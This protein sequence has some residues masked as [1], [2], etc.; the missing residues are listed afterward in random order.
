[1]EKDDPT[2]RALFP[3]LNADIRSA[4]KYQ[5]DAN[6]RRSLTLNVFPDE[7]DLRDRTY[8]PGLIQVKPTVPLPDYLLPIG[9]L[10]ADCEKQGVCRYQKSANS[11]LKHIEW[12]LERRSFI[13]RQGTE[14]SCT[15]QALAAVI[16][17]LKLRRQFGRPTGCF[18]SLKE[19]AEFDKWAKNRTSARMLYEMARNYEFAPE[20]QLS[21][22]TIRNALKAFYHNGVCS[23]AHAPYSAGDLSWV[24]SVERAKD[25][26]GTMLGSYFRVD[27]DIHE[28]QAALN[29]VGAI[30]ASGMVH[31]GWQNLELINDQATHS[32][33]NKIPERT[34][35]HRILGGHAFAVVGYNADGFY[36]LNSWGDS[37]GR[38]YDPRT[39]TVNE[40][41]PGVALWTYADWHRHALDAWVFRLTHPAAKTV[42]KK[43]GWR[44]N[45]H[46]LS[47]ERSSSEPRLIINGH[48]LHLGR[49]GLVR[50]GKYPSELD[51]FEQTK[52]YLEE[53]GHVEVPGVEKVKEIPGEKYQSLILCFMS[54]TANLESDANMIEAL[55]RLFKSERHYPVFVFWTYAQVA[56]IINIVNANR[57]TL[58]ERYGGSD[59]SL[60]FRVD[61]ELSEFGW[62]FR[63]RME[64]QIFDLV[65]LKYKDPS[66]LQAATM[67]LIEWATRNNKKIH[68]MA[69]SDGSLLLNNY[70]RGLKKKSE[71]IYDRLQQHVASCQLVAPIAIEAGLAQIADCVTPQCDIDLI[72]L[73]VEEELIDTVGNYTSTYP[74]MLQNVFYPNTSKH[75][76]LILGLYAHAGSAITRKMNELNIVSRKN[77]KSIA[78]YTHTVAP[79]DTRQKQPLHFNMMSNRAL[80]N[81]MLKKIGE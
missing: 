21:G 44:R 11:E 48:Y 77:E 4:L 39:Y 16:D 59:K 1:M 28:W 43:S 42:G 3:H 64:Q 25:A 24:L 18:S 66:P 76:N 36:V 33:P 58:I 60:R 47:G 63:A 53:E 14:G 75:E 12:E 13:R 81:V 26:R 19:E 38:V 2:I 57:D 67:P 22:S 32:L 5:Y 51:T 78:K 29:E 37:W 61:Q 9:S 40:G 56:H 69:H 23:E 34:S 74:Q 55:V 8:Q 31:D 54:G 30:L 20:S 35:E 72:T 17:I 73:T 6:T 27:S 52:R 50:R 71:L 80:V 15:G 62:L 46:N 7:A 45:T 49:G 68:L 65:D 41:I 10:C 79:R 70:L